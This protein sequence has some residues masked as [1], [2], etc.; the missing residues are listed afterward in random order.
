MTQERAV[1]IHGHFYQPPRENPWLE[2]IEVQDSAA[3]FHDWNERITAECYAPNGASRIL[4]EEGNI[5]RILNNYARLS[6]NVGPTLLSWLE[7][8]APEAYAAILEADRESQSLFSGHGSAIAQAYNHPILPLANDR[9]KVTQVHWGIADFEQRFG[10]H[11][12]GFWLPETAVDV[13]TLEILAGS[14]IRFVILAPHQIRRVRPIGTKPWQDVGSASVDPKMLYRVSLPSGA[15]IAVFPYDGPIAHELSFGT[16]LEDGEH[17]L[18]RL[19]SAF[20][21]SPTPQLVHIATDGEIYGH[22]RHFGDMALA[23]V[24]DHLENDDAIRLTNYGEW[25]EEHPPTHE[26]EIVEDSSWSCVHG[27]ERWR[28]DC[29]C[30]TGGHPGWNQAWRA[31]LR[32]ALDQLRDGLAPRFAEHAGALLADPWEAR[33]DYIRVVLDRSDASVDA[34]FAGHALRPLSEE[35]RIEA[36]KLLELQRHAMLMYTSCGWFFDDLAGI[37]TVQV[38]RYAGRVIDLAGQLFDEDFEP[39]FLAALESA[40]SN[41]PARGNGRAVYD[42]LVRPSIIDLPK[43]V[44]HHALAAPFSHDSP[45]SL[46]SAFRLETTTHEELHDESRFLRVGRVVVTSTITGDHETVAYA[47]LH[48]GGTNIVV[49]ARPAESEGHDSA[50]SEALLEAFRRDDLEGVQTGIAD[51]FGDSVYSLQ[52]LFREEQRRL[53]DRMM[54]KT[55]TEI[56]AAYCNDYKKTEPLLRLVADLG[57]PLPRVLKTLAAFMIN[58]DLEATVADI[59]IDTDQVKALFR[60]AAEWDVPLDRLAIAARWAEGLQQSAA[61]L[62]SPGDV[63]I[64]A[65]RGLLASV[66]AVQE[67]QME[68]D[69]WSVQNAYY[70]LAQEELPR[71]RERAATASDPNASDWLAVFTELGEHLR[72]D[73]APLGEA[74]PV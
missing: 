9:D 55:L 24:L 44:A 57:I 34:F 45:S 56:E 19:L 14:E 30:N 26:A 3:P 13:P 49:G 69:L 16:L 42:A 60:Q 54:A 68:V 50:V 7:G 27:I 29:G 46:F 4:D 63:A 53:L 25:L 35:E 28:A 32:Q 39:R 33:N 5:R 41:E 72:V 38:L 51:E 15:S 61:A 8:Q 2:V 22:H 64:D 47:A 20:T 10:R 17:L 65:L 31:P 71:V 40:S 18:Q 52:L 12:E 11:P 48:S 58:A 43:V 23:Y 73:I 67:V 6:F 36:V 66:V 1:C 62:T 70:H 37:E 59:P 21:D 74:P